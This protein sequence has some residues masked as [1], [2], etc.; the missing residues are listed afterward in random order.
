[1]AG[2]TIGAYTTAGFGEESNWSTGVARTNW[3][4]LVGWSLQREREPV[5]RDHLGFLDARA[6]VRRDSYIA[7]DYS[8]GPV[9]TVVGYNDSTALLLKHIMGAVATS[10]AGPFLHEYT[11]AG[12]LP[13]GV[14][15]LTIE[16]LRGSGVNAQAEVF[17]GCLVQ[18]ATFSIEVEKNFKVRTEFIAYD[19]GGAVAAGT[20]TYNVTAEC[21]NYNHFGDFTWD[22]QSRKLVSMEFVVDRMISQRLKLGD[23]RTVEPTQ[24]NFMMVTGTLVVESGDDND[25]T[26][27]DRWYTKYL[28]DVKADGSI[29]ATGTGNNSMAIRFTDMEMV[30]RSAPING[31][32]IIQETFNFRAYSNGTN[33]PIEIDLQNDNATPETN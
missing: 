14:E 15:G 4:P 30:S 7:K 27:A 31:P 10:G 11:M 3:L 25:I 17:T 23:L 9:E 21:V 26:I 29:T 24:N 5:E 16:G 12:M 18:R 33:L 28:N 20:P 6:P 19:S 2:P 32:D 8:S 22:G 13:A 1:M